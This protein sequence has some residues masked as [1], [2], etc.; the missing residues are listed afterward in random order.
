VVKA[1]LL[2]WADGGWHLIDPLT[3]D[4]LARAS[5]KS[6]DPIIH[7]HNR[8]IEIL[9]TFLAVPADQAFPGLE[10][11]LKAAKDA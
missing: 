11:S 9:E 3:G 2:F 8:D 4:C 5:A 1:N 10:Q 6:L 7:A